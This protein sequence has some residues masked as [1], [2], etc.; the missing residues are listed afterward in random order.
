MRDVGKKIKQI[1]SKCTE[2]RIMCFWILGWA[3]I[4]ALLFGV[5]LL[6]EF[7]GLLHLP[8]IKEDK[9]FCYT[10]CGVITAIALLNYTNLT[11]LLSSAS[12]RLFGI[13]LKDMLKKC[14]WRL[15][16]FTVFFFSTIAIVMAVGYTMWNQKIIMLM[17]IFL[18]LVVYT[19][20]YCLIVWKLIINSKFVSD[21]IVFHLQMEGLQGTDERKRIIFL[22]INQLEKLEG[23]EKS[24]AIEVIKSALSV[25]NNELTRYFQK[26]LTK[27]L[28]Y[29]LRDNKVRV[30]DENGYKHLCEI[31]LIEGFNYCDLL[32]EAYR[33]IQKEGDESLNKYLQMKK[34]ENVIR[35]NP[36]F[37]KMYDIIH[38]SWHQEESGY[39]NDENTKRILRKEFTRDLTEKGI[40][41]AYK[42]LLRKGKMLEFTDKELE[43]LFV[44]MYEPLCY[45][46]PEEL[47]KYEMSRVFPEFID[48][49]IR[50][51]E[52]SIY[53]VQ[54]AWVVMSI[55]IKGLM[56]NPSFAREKKGRTIILLIF[57]ALEEYEKG[58]YKG[59]CKEEYEEF[60][61]LMV[62]YSTLLVIQSGE[63]QDTKEVWINNLLNPIFQ[64]LNRLREICKKMIVDFYLLLGYA[65][66]EKAISEGEFDVIL[67]F[68]VGNEAR[69]LNQLCK[70][71]YDKFQD[72]QDPKVIGLLLKFLEKEEVPDHVWQS[73][74][75]EYKERVCVVDEAGKDETK[76]T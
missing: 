16:P 74:A 21:F 56:Q 44:K 43:D 40:R 49:F 55:Y 61:R 11:V 6:E 10:M 72:Y 50:E 8:D 20:I 65:K 28:S 22:V 31:L 32:S 37:K 46:G 34:I 35:S 39:D 42:A 60:L 17:L 33:L 45:A 54:L 9:D 30:E 69:T 68:R 63:D 62:L 26:V 76:E 57:V 14:K 52:E 48:L 24:Y 67:D 64:Y 23:D 41:S 1:T 66:K 53:T 18:W 47:G 51:G 71:Y 38:P 59:R 58:N 2:F 36:A 25:N 73:I 70:N 4:G 75:E 29:D 15:R 19:L 5:S 3:V 12:N 13:P 27:K 7:S